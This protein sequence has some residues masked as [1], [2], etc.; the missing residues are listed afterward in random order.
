MISVLTVAAGILLVLLRVFGF[1]RD[2]KL[3]LLNFVPCAVLFAANRLSPGA[4][5]TGDILVAGMLGFLLPGTELMRCMILGILAGRRLGTDKKS[6]EAWRAEGGDTAGSFYTAG[7]YYGVLFMKDGKWKRSGALTVEASVL[8]GTLCIVAGILISLT[9]HVYQRAWYTAAA[10]GKRPYRQ[11][12]RCFKG[13]GRRGYD[14]GKMGIAPGILL[15][16]A[17]GLVRAGRRR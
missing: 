4:V 5:G 10:C 8:F 16:R 1:S 12:E 15:S 11:R 7:L 13:D 3:T 2:W 9:L 17:G 6:M 14:A